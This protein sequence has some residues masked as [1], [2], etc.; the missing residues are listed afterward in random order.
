MRIS[1]RFKYFC[2]NGEDNVVV[3]VVVVVAAA[4]LLL[5]LLLLM[6]FRVTGSYDGSLRVWSTSSW[7]SICITTTAHHG[8]KIIIFSKHTRP[9]LIKNHFAGGVL[10][11]QMNDRLY[12]TGGV[13]K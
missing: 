6:C 11:L 13:D 3:V 4:A 10:C 5:L 7:D 8:M 2:P 12:A 1:C 9:G